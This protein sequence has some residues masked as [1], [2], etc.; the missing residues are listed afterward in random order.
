MSRQRAGRVVTMA[1]LVASVVL[2]VGSLAAWLG[3][4]ERAVGGDLPRTEVASS[5]GAGAVEGPAAAGVTGEPATG[6]PGQPT[7]SPGS[8]GPLVAAAEV[9]RTDATRITRPRPVAAPTRVSIPAVDV[10]MPIRPTGVRGDGQMDLP[11]D[12]REIG[13][14][15]FGAAP[16]DRRGSAVLGGHVDSVRFGVGPLAR[17]AAVEVG[18]LVRVTHEDGRRLGY[19]VSEV[20]R[21]SKAALPVEELFDPDVRHRLVVITCGGRYLPE[22]GGYEDNIVVIATPVPA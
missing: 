16:G 7:A 21:I 5:A 15:R 17:L 18:D 11:A 22:A 4:R 6:E 13:W 19:R 12:P 1:A 20:V 3:G 8:A 2:L 9:P 14:Y 10:V